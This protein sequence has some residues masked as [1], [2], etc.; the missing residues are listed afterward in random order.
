MFEESGLGIGRLAF[1]EPSFF[2]M[3]VLYEYI[4]DGLVLS[5]GYA[6]ETKF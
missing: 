6:P 5:T 3:F 4:R 2:L 1:S